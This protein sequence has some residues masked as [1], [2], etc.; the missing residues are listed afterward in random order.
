MNKIK[1][2]KNFFVL[3]GLDGAG[4]STVANLVGEKAKKEGI[5][6]RLDFEP[7]QKIPVKETKKELAVFFA[8]DRREHIDGPGGVRDFLANGGIVLCDRYLFSSL[9][10]QSQDLPFEEVLALNSHF[11]L[12][13]AVF[14]LEIDLETAQSRIKKRGDKISPFEDIDFQKNV[15]QGYEKSFKIFPNINLIR[16]K[17]ISTEKIVEKIFNFFI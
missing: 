7:T 3:E 15:L 12:P 2:L 1:T 4:K 5:R 13:E 6:F 9:A 16:F 8:Q 17:K 10:Y 14:F 11:P